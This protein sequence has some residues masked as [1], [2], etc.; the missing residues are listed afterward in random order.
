MNSIPKL[1]FIQDIIYLWL[2][3]THFL[4]HK[5]SLCEV[6][7]QTANSVTPSHTVSTTIKGPIGQCCQGL[8][9]PS[10]RS[11]HHPSWQCHMRCTS[12]P[13]GDKPDDLSWIPAMHSGRWG[14]L[15]TQR[16]KIYPRKCDK[17]V[18]SQKR[19]HQT[20]LL[21]IWTFIL[22]TMQ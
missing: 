8:N 17:P 4:Y 14:T 22:Q 2:L 20:V 1:V 13:W 15:Y 19:L 21:N 12:K 6:S 7:Q 10:P 9:N 3:W 18:T 5:N 16:G 11:I